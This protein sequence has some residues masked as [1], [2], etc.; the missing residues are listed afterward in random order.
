[1]L[2]LDLN[3]QCFHLKRVIN[4]SAGEGFSFRL[5]ALMIKAELK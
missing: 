5:A 3:L 4:E 1:M 2:I